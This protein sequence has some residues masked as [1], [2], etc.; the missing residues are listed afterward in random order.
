MQDGIRFN[1]EVYVADMFY[2]PDGTAISS[3]PPQPLVIDTDPREMGYYHVPTYMANQRGDLG[4]YVPLKAFLSIENWVHVFMA[5]C[6]FGVFAHG[7]R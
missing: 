5:N 4:F 1:G 6:P 3:T 2:Y 7:A